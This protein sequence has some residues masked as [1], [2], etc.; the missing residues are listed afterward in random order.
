[1]DIIEGDRADVVR[2]R[3]SKPVALCCCC[4][5]WGRGVP[6]VKEDDGA[7]AGAE[8]EGE[9]TGFCFCRCFW[10]WGRGVP[11]VEKDD[12]VKVGTKVEGEGIVTTG[13]CFGRN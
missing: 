1:M 9:V 13:F 2:A 12:G 8:V 6:G 5:G 11:G 10:G 7:K 4:W 3:R